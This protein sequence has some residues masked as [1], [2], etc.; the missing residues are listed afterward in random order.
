M[1]EQPSRTA[2]HPPGYCKS[3]KLLF[4]VIG[5][6]ISNSIGVSLRG[7]RTRCLRCGEKNAEILD[8]TYNAIG[9]RLEIIFSSGVSPEARTALARLIAAVQGNEIALDDAKRQA[10]KISPKLGK[11]F[12]IENWS[13]E[14]KAAFF[15]SVLLSIATFAGAAAT[16][17]APHFAPPTIVQ[18]VNPPPVIPSG[19][20]L[21]GALLAGA[22]TIPAPTVSLKP[23]KENKT[24]SPHGHGR[25]VRIG[26]DHRHH[27]TPQPQSE[28]TN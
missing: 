6:V 22:A 21:R 15:G 23:V 10:E 20:G 26:D 16:L 3:C 19:R 14:A 8:G 9:D 12:D 28:F 25:S 13:G 17:A 18:V 24:H 2:H 1:N 4:P 11:I 7:N 5:I 27:S